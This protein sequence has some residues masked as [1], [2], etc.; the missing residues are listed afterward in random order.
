MLIA[1][2]E[3]K[4]Q[5]RAEGLDIDRSHDLRESLNMKVGGVLKRKVQRGDLPPLSDVSN[6][7]VRACMSDFFVGK[8]LICCGMLMLLS[9]G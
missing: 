2:R 5:G 6:N 1:V 7:A 3:S 8:V 9:A 4:W